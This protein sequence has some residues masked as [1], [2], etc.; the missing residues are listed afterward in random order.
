MAKL[1]HVISTKQFMDTKLLDDIFDLADLMEKD[2]LSGKTKPVLSGK[3]MAS[4]FYEPSTRTRFSFE[5]AMHKL[6]GGVVMTEAAPMFSSAA[7]GESL[8]DAMKIIS[9]YSDVIVLRHP[10]KGSAKVASESSDVPVLNAGDGTGEHPT[11]ALLDVYT[12]RKEMGKIDGLKV[13]LVG[14]LKNGRT[15]H[16]LINLLALYKGVK[17]FLV[18]PPQ[19]KLPDE[20]KAY[21]KEKNLPFEEMAEVAPILKDIDVMYV[22]RIQKE[23]FTDPAEYEKL[24]G[25]YVVD[26]S[27]LAKMKGHSIIMHPLPRVG[28]IAIEVDKDK[29]AAY[30]RQAK[31]GMYIRMALLKMVLQK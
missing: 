26:N 5:T 9:G 15:V 23:R 30:F 19:L 14:D 8:S 16:S 27:M 6:G 25:A 28:E 12:I 29:R 11:Q 13:A 1:E 7:K 2:D 20:Y 17:V 3:V 21:M 10:E 18:S 24:K 4:V 31:N 22:T